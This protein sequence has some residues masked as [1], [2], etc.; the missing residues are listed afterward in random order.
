MKAAELLAVLDEQD[1]ENRLWLF[2][3]ASFR[4]LFPEE[5]EDSLKMSLRRHVKSGLLRQVKKGLY[6]NERARCAPS[7]KL[8]ALVPFLK[9][10]DINYLSQESRLS[11]LG[12]ISQ[13]PLN[14]LSIMTRGN[15][16]TFNTLYGKVQ[17]THTKRPMAFILDHTTVDRET[18]LLVADGHL[19]LKDL[20][21]SNRTT[22]ELVDEQTMKDIHEK[23]F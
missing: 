18:G 8:P 10:G 19:A 13:M 20:M 16:Q 22:R 11:Q 14:Y 5:S 3:P 1:R 17:F 9:P 6:A 21:R 12:L 4:V 2:T 7:D 15:T 23:V